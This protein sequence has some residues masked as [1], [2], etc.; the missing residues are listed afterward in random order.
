MKIKKIIIGGLLLIVALPV[1]LILTAFACFYVLDKTNGTM[2]SSGLARRYL[3]YV[4]KTYDRTKPTP[5]I[6]SIHP[7]ATWPAVE[8]HIS[9]WNDLA[10][11]YGFLVVYPAGTGAFFSGLG[12]G[13][14]VWHGESQD[15][16]FISDLIDKLEAEYNI[17][18]N[19]I[20]ADGMSNGGG[21]AFVLT[22]EL[23]NRI[24]AVGAVASA[25][26]LPWDCNGSQPSRYRRWRFM[27][28]PI[29]LPPTRAG[30]RRSPRRD[31]RIFRSGQRMWRNET[32][33]RA[34]PSKLESLRASAVL[35]TQIALTMQT[36]FF[37]RSR[38]EA[39]PGRVANTWRNGSPGTPLMTSTPP[40]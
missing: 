11:H 35:R 36:S 3:L 17:D 38:V 40:E 1:V 20:Y 12:P 21:M 14:Q 23:S 27:A 32:T 28:P 9:R 19:R 34:I 31:L 15:V 25:Q 13:P 10:D 24:A 30:D 33:A 5:L 16:R 29:S 2:V 18:P 8:M 22:C 4:P 6:I 7:A 37:I 26:V 39:T